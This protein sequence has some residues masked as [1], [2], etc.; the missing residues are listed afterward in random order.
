MGNKKILGVLWILL[1]FISIAQN[2]SKVGKGFNAYPENLVV[3]PTHNVLYAFSNFITIAGGVPVHY[4]AMLVGNEWDS[5]PF[6]HTYYPGKKVI[7]HNNKLIFG[8][9][10]VL[11]WDG[12]QIDTIANFNWGGAL[13]FTIYNNDLVVYGSFDSIGGIAANSIAKW[14]GINWSAFDTTKW[15]QGITATIEYQGDLYAGGNFSNFDGSLKRLARWNGTKWLPVGNG[16]HGGFASV[17]SF[18]IYNGDLYI[19]GGFTTL[20]GNPGNSIARWDGAQWKDVGIGMTSTNALI[21][22][23]QVYNG[24]LYASGNFRTVDN[25]PINAIAKWNGLRWCGLGYSEINNLITTMAVYNNELYMG[26]LFQTIDGDTMNYVAKWVGGN[27]TDTCGEITA[28][29]EIA[30]TSFTLSPNPTSA[31]LTLQLTNSAT[32]N[33]TYQILTTDGRVLF[34]NKITTQPNI[35]IDVSQLPSGLYFLQLQ[36]DKQRVVRK[37]VKQ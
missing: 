12:H 14:N 30:E 3:E 1:P 25:M 32:T 29:N 2:W 26:G 4:G 17:G 36:D 5:I 22:D 21:R 16:I 23:L 15:Y 11:S 35:E 8:E 9:S 24:E 27:Y 6:L 13:G 7:S 34:Q 28:I 19:G 18:E 10:V 20:Q 33:L 31:K 37:F